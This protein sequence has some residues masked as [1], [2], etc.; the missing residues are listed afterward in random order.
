MMKDLLRTADLSCEDVALLMGLSLKFKANPFKYPCALRNESVVL[1]FAKPSTRTRISFETAVARLGGQPIA[2]SAHELQLGRG[3]T[4]EDTARVVSRYA[5]AF[6]IRTYDDDDVR[7]FARAATIP[8]INALTDEHH[9]LQSLA[10]LLTIREKCGGWHGRKVAYVGDGN[11][12]AHSLLEAC[13]L[14][15]MS[16]AVATPAEFAPKSDIVHD[17]RVI[18]AQTGG[19][20]FVTSDPYEAVRDADAVYTDV[21]LSMGTPEAERS[22]RLKLFAPYQVTAALM[23]KAGPDS[24]FM[25]CLPDHRGEEVAAEVVDGP[26]SVIF[27]QAENRLH[28]AK[29]VLFALLEG[30]LRGR[31][32][33]SQQAAA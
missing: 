27:D 7:R 20:I 16:I 10:D 8:V 22:N 11:N 28:T 24:I 18:A 15:G 2:V 5:R 19:K 23:A 14:A 29:A 4:I 12:V 13:A 3:E 6:V 9:P 26:R 30:L 21:W 32:E 17:A 1:Y 25:H 33:A 31:A